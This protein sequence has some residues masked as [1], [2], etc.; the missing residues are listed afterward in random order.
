MREM[1]FTIEETEALKPGMEVGV[2][3][4]VL[5]TSYYYTIEHALGMSANFKQAERLKTRRGIV[6]ELK[7]TPQFHIAVLE[8]DEQH[9]KMLLVKKEIKCYS[10]N[11]TN[12]I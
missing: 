6:K 3:E 9:I 7:E 12:N 8:F 5:P 2:T 11:K 10:M 1:E 4:G